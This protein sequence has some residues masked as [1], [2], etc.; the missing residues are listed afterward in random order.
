MTGVVH[1]LPLP[2]RP[3]KSISM[4]YLMGYPTT[5]H[6]HDAILLV[7]DKFFKMDILI[8]CKNTM[9]VQQCAH[10]FFENVWKH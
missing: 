7:V 9:T 4:D 8:P 6:Q 5:K 10:R 1:M 3:W 2:S